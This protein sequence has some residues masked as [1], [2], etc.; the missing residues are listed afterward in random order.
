M[1]CKHLRGAILPKL[2]MTIGAIWLMIYS[3]AIAIKKDDIGILYGIKVNWEL[4]LLFGL[5][6]ILI[7]FS[8]KI[9]IWSLIWACLIGL[10]SIL[11]LIGSFTKVD[12]KSVWTY[13]GGVPYIFLA[14]GAILW[15]LTSF[16]GK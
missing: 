1:K 10:I 14:L 12:Y 5:T 16:K 9:G 11:L 15:A 8:V 2:L 3:V 4:L 6:Y 7:P 13:L